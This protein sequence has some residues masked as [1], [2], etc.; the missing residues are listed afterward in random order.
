MPFHTS[1]EQRKRG[2]ERRQGLEAGV[3]G[4]PGGRELSPEEEVGAGR[5]E[6]A[7]EA[8]IEE[9][10]LSDI[11]DDLRGVMETAPGNKR[12]RLEKVLEEL[13]DIAKLTPEAGE[14]EEAGEE[15]LGGELELPT[16]L[17][18]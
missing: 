9:S 16:G 4:G 18:L 13:E 12:A 7:E 14:A 1:G 11:I 8:L 6:R 2:L 15:A 10:P 5:E 3:L 17:G